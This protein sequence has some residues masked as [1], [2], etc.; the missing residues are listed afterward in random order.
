M[1]NGVVTAFT[2]LILLGSCGDEAAS[3]IDT[4]DTTSPSDLGLD[5]T[6]PDGADNPDSADATASDATSPVDSA[7]TSDTASPDAPETCVD[8]CVAL[9]GD[10][11]YGVCAKGACVFSPRAGTCDDG[12][13][14][15]I[16]DTCVDGACSGTPKTCASTGSCDSAGTCDAQ[17]GEC[18]FDSNASALFLSAWDLWAQALPEATITLRDTAGSVLASGPSIEL[19]LCAPVTLDV[20]ATAP[21]HHTA[22]VRF[23][24]NGASGSTTSSPSAD[25]AHVLRSTEDGLTLDLG[26]AHHWFA[27]AGSP[28]R[29]GNRLELLMNGEDA[30][31]RL[32]GDLQ[33]AQ[34]LVTGST[35]WW[36]S[37]L[38]IIRNRATDTNLSPAQRWAN[39][40]L[41][42]LERRPDIDKKI[43]V[44][45]FIGQDGLFSGLTVDDELEEKGEVA[46]DRFDY[47]GQA[48][49][50]AGTFTVTLPAVDF[51]ARLASFGASTLAAVPTAPFLP[52]IAVDTTELPLGLSIFD[53]PIASWH[54]KFWTFD[55]R[56]AFIGG[57]NAKTSDW[58]T[59]AHRVFEPLRMEFDASASRRG[60]VANRKKQSDHVPRKDY[61]VR[62]DGPTAADAVAV[63]HRRWEH[64]RQAGVEYANNA[65]AFTRADI[66]A[67]HRDG[68]QAQVL[69][70]MPA[71]FSDYSILE[72]MLRAVSQAE[73]YILIEDQYFRAPILYDAIITRMGSEPNLVLIVVSN[74]VSEWTDPGCWQTAIAYDRFKRLFPGRFRI[75]QTRTYDVVRTDCTFCWDETEAH[76]VDIALHSK[77]VIVDD[78]FLQAGSCNSNNRGLL[79]EGELAV[80]VHDPL[81]VSRSRERILE[82]LIGV[83]GSGAMVPSQ[84]ISRLD[85]AAAV[86]QTAYD[87]WDD[88]G[89]DLDLDGDPIP[90]G[91]TPRGFLYPLV[92]DD[93]DECLFENVGPDVM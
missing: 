4:T 37:E 16:A 66:P 28:A 5:A 91:H 65:T 49:P 74:T 92:F 42:A 86:N 77:L 24:W 29:H 78:R 53:L 35:W 7:E 11:R 31:K 30:W 80:A 83:P 87:N 69:A 85:S 64:L 12:D 76:F 26:L 44:G 56:I 6:A 23:V 58:D 17:T 60:D 82:H 39:T 79:Y 10:C 20:T 2:A 36:T 19:P 47:M 27:S 52:P 25:Y 59:S 72:S 93:P 88:E 45:Q 75:Y 33:A 38:E 84:M 32:H 46:N 63:F 71:P 81:F 1:R 55:Q 67:P 8:D 22:T 48:N 57:M 21:L 70:T 89:F 41:G 43:I 15:T 13:L 40:I 73:S 34:S 50:S 54:Q 51:A 61:M 3:G 14:C 68:I 90:N 62:I 9:A 18:V